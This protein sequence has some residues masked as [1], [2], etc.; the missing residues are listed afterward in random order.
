L[1][2]KFNDLSNSD[3]QKINNDYMSMVSKVK[4]K[5][6][7]KVMT[8]GLSF[9]TELPRI[10]KLTDSNFKKFKEKYKNIDFSN[11]SL[12]VGECGLVLKENCMK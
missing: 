12:F 1:S 5:E 2:W 6:M 7:N 4:E 8:S 10:R 11:A 9:K 3:K